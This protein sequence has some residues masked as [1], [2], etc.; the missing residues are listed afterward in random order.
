[1]K[2]GCQKTGF[3][4]YPKF[5]AIFSLN[6]SKIA[7]VTRSGAIPLIV[8]QKLWYCAGWTMVVACVIRDHSISEIRQSETKFCYFRGSWLNVILSIS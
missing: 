3:W 8:G 5:S 1:M 4:V 7:Q 6:L 2:I